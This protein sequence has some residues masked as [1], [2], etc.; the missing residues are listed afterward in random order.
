M[1][2]SRSLEERA[3]ALLERIAPFISSKHGVSSMAYSIYDTAWASMVVKQENRRSRWAFPECFEFILRSQNNA[4]GWSSFTDPIPH[5]FYPDHVVIPDILVHTLAALLA[6]CVHLRDKDKVESTIPEDISERIERGRVYA[7]QTLERWN[8]SQTSHFEFQLLIPTTLGLLSSEGVVFDFP[9]KTLL[10]DL[11]KLALAMDVE[12]LYTEKNE[13]PLFS[14]EGWLAKL[15]FTRLTHQV[16]TEGIGASPAS[17]AAYLIYGPEWSTE[18][19]EYLQNCIQ[20]AAG[21]DR[22]GVP[23]IW[24]LTLF[25]PCWVLT[26]LFDGGF[27][28]SDLGYQRVET[29]VDFLVHHHNSRGGV[30][31]ASPCWT[32]DADDSGRTLTALYLAGRTPSPMALVHRFEKKSHFQTFNGR[33]PSVIPSVSVHANILSGLLLSPE[34]VKLTLQIVKCAQVLCNSWKDGEKISDHWNISEYYAILHLTLGLVRLHDTL[35]TNIFDQSTSKRLI[36][37]TVPLLPKV[38]SYIVDNQNTDG[39]WGDRGSYEET[40]YAVI[41]LAK[42][43]KLGPLNNHERVNSTIDLGKQ[44]ITKWQQPDPRDRVWTGK[45][46]HAS[47]FIQ[48]AYVLAALRACSV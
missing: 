37:L 34:A 16:S 46:M 10:Y 24:P 33:I 29:I 38:L 22:G 30:S 45:I 25:E 11:H 7:Q 41:A 47:L 19:E 31:S 28:L 9:G 4:G 36:D 42:L 20:H 23:G 3:Q 18:C 21:S 17:T 48:E 2:G 35:S 15:D 12:W 1:I 44:F 39:S 8:V 13:V 5:N 27:S 14:I 32:P 43:A 26:T 6:L 40:A